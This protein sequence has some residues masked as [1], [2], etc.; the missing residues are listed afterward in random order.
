MKHWPTRWDIPWLCVSL[1]FLYTPGT[2]T[3]II[4]K[5][6]WVGRR[7]ANSTMGFGADLDRCRRVTH[8][9][10]CDRHCRIYEHEERSLRSIGQDLEERINGQCSSAKIFVACLPREKREEP[11]EK[12]KRIVAFHLPLWSA[13]TPFGIYTGSTFRVLMTPQFQVSRVI[14]Y[15]YLHSLCVP[16]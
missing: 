1:V 10:E 9:W 15:V 8:T 7:S 11:R 4:V 16:R 2:K 14:A 5:K 3:Q 13:L 6:N 12:K